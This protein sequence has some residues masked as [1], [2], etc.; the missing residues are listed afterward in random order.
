LEQYLWQE[1][2]EFRPGLRRLIEEIFSK[3]LP[4]FPVT[5]SSSW[6]I[7]APFPDADGL[8]L[9]VWAEMVPGHYYWLNQAHQKNGTFD[10]LVTRTQGFQYIQFLG[11]DN[12]FFYV[13]A[14]LALSL[15]ARQ[16]G[17]ET[18]VPTAFI[19]NEFL[20]LEN[21]KFSTSQGHLIWG[22][23]LLSEAPVDNVRFYLAWVNP[24]YNQANFSRQDFESVSRKKFQEPLE[25][26]IANL[27]KL[28]M[29]NVSPAFSPFTRSMVHRFEA[30]YEPKRPSL[31]MAALTLANGLALGNA[32]IARREAPGTIQAIA[33]VLA[34][35]SAP[36]VPDTASRLWA[37]AGGR[38]PISWPD[39]DAQSVNV[40]RIA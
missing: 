9:N 31:R 32:L 10:A 6:G 27:K 25:T 22:R 30:A 20:Q 7:K 26:L 23:D 14:H 2:P 33:Q 4:P 17:V 36:L 19:T 29:Q 3:P 16:S 35:G 11:F 24:E 39:L 12:S 5:F 1:I 21:F 40:R 38:G 34:A 28:D 8:V 13:I 18:L 15:A 37:A